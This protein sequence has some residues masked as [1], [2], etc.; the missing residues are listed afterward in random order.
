[1]K[2]LVMLAMIILGSLSIQ[3]QKSEIEITSHVY[4]VKGQ[5]SLKLDLYLREDLREVDSLPVMLYVHGGGFVTGSRINAAQEVFVRHYA[6]QGYLGVSIDY[7]LGGSTPEQPSRYGCKNTLEAIRLAT[8]DLADA[9]AWLLKN[10]KVNPRRII[11]AGGSAGAMT[12]MQAEYDLCN[13]EPYICRALPEGFNYAGVV[14]AAGAICTPVGA[15]LTWQQMP[16]PL[17]MLQGD[18]DNVVNESVGPAL[19]LRL[20]RAES[21]SRQLT[22]TGQPHWLFLEKGADHVVAMKHLTDNLEETDKFIRTF[23]NEGRRSCV[24]TEWSDAEPPSM[25]DV[26]EMVRWVPLYILG[27]EKYLKDMDFNNIEK[28]VGI[29]Y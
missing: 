11:I 13:R 27:Y 18:E 26:Q 15:E 23:I 14:S 3:A 20:F 16:C 25:R 5:D 2:K 22:E 17:F 6:E 19:S 7:R 1:M 12:V 28:P 8:T 9:T 29:V 21:I 10:C 24:R 4:A